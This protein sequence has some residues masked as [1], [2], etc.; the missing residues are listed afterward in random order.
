MVGLAVQTNVRIDAA[1]GLIWRT[2]YRDHRTPNHLNTPQKPY[3]AIKKRV[4]C[5]WEATGYM[6]R[7]LG[8]PPCPRHL[9]QCLAL[10]PRTYQAPPG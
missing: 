5:M 3:S 6:G 10:V 9:A 8:R 7:P 4:G 1:Y 2:D